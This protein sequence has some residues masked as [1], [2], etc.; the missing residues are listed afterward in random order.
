MSN[1][2]KP[3]KNCLV[4]GKENNTPQAK[5]CSNKCQLV[6]QRKQK[7]EDKIAN[8][9]TIKNHLID[10][11]G[12]GCEQCGLKIWLEKSIPIEMDHINGIYDDNRLE[13]LRLL[14]LNCHGLTPTYR[15]K[16]KG[17]GRHTRRERYQKGKSY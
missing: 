7:V 14:C 13:N 12:Y 16:N 15:A 6:F 3:R 1:P 5:Y 8:H 9:R 2:R 4:C 17:N 11:R 10:I